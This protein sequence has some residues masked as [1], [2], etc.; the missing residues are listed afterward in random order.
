MVK[1]KN[2]SFSYQIENEKLKVD[3]L[4]KMNLHVKEG[5]FVLL[6]GNSGC[7]K[8][9]VIR[10]I[11]GLIP[12]YHKGDI[13]GTVKIDGVNIIDQ[14][15]SHTAK[16]VG[17][18][19]QNPRSQFFN[20]NTTNELAF[21]LENQGVKREKIME[22]IQV[23]VKELEIEDLLGR[24]L[25]KLSGGEKQKIAC[26]SVAVAGT[27]VIVLDEPSSNLDAK[28][29]EKLRQLLEKWKKEGKTIIIAEHRLY[30]L[31]DL[32]DRMLVMKNGE[33][34]KELNNKE[35]KILSYEEQKEMEIRTLD[36]NILQNIE[37]KVAYQEKI[38]I[39]DLMFHYPN[40]KKGMKID[41]VEIKK[42]SIVAVIG[43]NGAGK[44]TF[45]KCM[46]GLHKKSKGVL[47]TESGIYNSKK[48]LKNCYMVMQDVNHQLFMESVGDEV[49]LSLD[50]NPVIEE[51][52][53]DN[54][55]KKYLREFDLEEYE[56]EHP[57]ALS[58]GQKQR[59]AIAAAVASGR[60]VMIFDEPTSG[61]DYL[62]MRQVAKNLKSISRLGKTI[63]VITHD[64]E[65]IMECC[66]D[67]MHLED[68]KL[69]ELYKIDNTKEKRLKDYFIYA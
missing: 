66:T 52:E 57:M 15:I 48:R 5:E 45:A 2:L 42:G 36:M 41:Q 58:G 24:S 55:I 29:I 56:K 61:L 16:V 40:T 59:V 25:F 4:K 64:L 22:R 6:T 65:L 3:Q 50:A 27:E 9:T 35:I 23:T 8:T 21:P 13:S 46:C 20:V 7:G 37:H 33:I 49:R 32:T 11:N 51:K 39:K 12:N 62:R 67:V 43:R 60:E 47:K 69:E 18:V 63:F 53:K 54:L 34:V 28:A 44:T 14:A 19:F 17:S 68:G 30:F 31:R 38:S 26:A 10:L 1:I